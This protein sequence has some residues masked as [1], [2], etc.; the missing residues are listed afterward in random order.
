M[1]I[2]IEKLFLCILAGSE[3]FMSDQNILEFSM[4]VLHT[5][6]ITTSG[7]NEV[8]TRIY[9]QQ[10]LV[11]LYSVGYNSDRLNILSKKSTGG[12]L[13][14]VVNVTIYNERNIK[15]IRSV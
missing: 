12:C 3:L 6:G 7:K 2:H 8:E 14:C 13:V 9:I 4:P 15:S 10:S 5:I 1:D 11:Y